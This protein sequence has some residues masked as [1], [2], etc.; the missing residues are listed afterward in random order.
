MATFSGG[1][2]CE[3]VEKPPKIVQSE[4]PICLQILR[5][6]YQV[7]CCGYAF[8]QVCIEK[9]KADDKPCPCCMAKNFQKFEDKRLK[10]ML[11]EFKVY[12]TNQQQ[13]CMWTGELIQLD[14]H[15][16]SN[17]PKEKQLQ[18]CQY[19]SVKCL[20]CSRLHLRSA[21]HVHQGDECLRRPFSCEYC[22]D[23]DSN[24]EDVTT[25]H[26]PICGYYPVKCT[27][28]CEKKM[29]RQDLNSH[30]FSNCP[31]TIIDCEFSYVGCKV[32]LPRQ[33]MA[34]HLTENIG[35]HLSLTTTNYKV[36][37]NQLKEENKRLEKQVAK[38]TEDLKLQQIL[39]T[40]TCPVEFTMT[41]FEQH[42][43]DKDMWYS[44]PF[45]THLKGYKM[46]ILV[47]ANEHSD[48]RGTHASVEVRVMKGEFDDQLKWPLKGSTTIRL[49]SQ[50]NEGYIQCG[51]N[52]VHT[53]DK[54]TEE[55]TEMARSRVIN[56]IILTSHTTLRA[57]YLRNDCVKICVYKFIQCV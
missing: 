45:Y 43:R 49:L 46:C 21:I 10:R 3:F 14:N 11:Y 56:D 19:T 40:P 42:T 28:G 30:I 12:C 27:N 51:N 15:V 44:P 31:L 7:D 36:V 5:D 16:N 33:D 29:K 37:V 53:F 8:C 2:D 4:C 35:N 54:I 25:N 20:Y 9:A 34:A 6:P 26:W 52:L 32:K 41:N 17:P 50:V 39:S 24:Y 23:F 13:G 57:K 22:Q 18:G 38:L 48:C 55:E 1:Y 47:K